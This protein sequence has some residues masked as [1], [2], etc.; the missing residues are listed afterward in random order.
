MTL[1]SRSRYVLGLLMVLACLAGCATPGVEPPPETRPTED[2]FQRGVAALTNSAY[3]QAIAH[4]T[5]ALRRDPRRVE[6]FHNR[7]EA[8]RRKG[9]YDR[10]LADYTQALTINPHYAHA[11]YNRG[12]VYSNKGAYDE[13]IAD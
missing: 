3:D 8:Y 9:E 4:F 13:A 7:G 12:I 10:A 6:A 1:H 2:A 11:Y 5:E